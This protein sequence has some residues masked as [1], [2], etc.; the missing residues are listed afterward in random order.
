MALREMHPVVLTIAGSDSG[1]GAGIQTDLKTFQ[2]LDCF[3]TS[4]ITCVTAQNPDGVRAVEA[5][6]TSLVGEQIKAV[7]EGFP[8]A[9]AKT[10]M[11][12]SAEVVT[13]VA[14]TLGALPR[15]DWLVVDPVMVATSGSRL[16]ADSAV[17]ALC[18]CLLPRADVM[19]PNVPEAEVLS[20]RSITSED[21]QRSVAVELSKRFNVICVLKG[22]HLEGDALLDVCACGEMIF[23]SWAKRVA[24]DETHG[25]GCTYAAAMTAYLARG[26]EPERAF[27]QAQVFVGRALANA[28]QCGAHTPLCIS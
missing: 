23:E 19:T 2:A 26:S 11:L 17:E 24:I 15:L 3:G 14:E 12:Y 27:A 28:W 9:A 22:G 5:V 10:G 8:V 6:A 4:A 7:C 25:T 18:E 1:G 20:G 16:M 21:D 13:T